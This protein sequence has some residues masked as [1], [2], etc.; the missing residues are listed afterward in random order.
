MIV[1]LPLPYFNAHII[2]AFARLKTRFLTVN[3]RSMRKPIYIIPFGFYRPITQIG[4]RGPF[5][6]GILPEVRV[7]YPL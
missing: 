5:L 6:L 7:F 2:S 3:P 1:I 4:F